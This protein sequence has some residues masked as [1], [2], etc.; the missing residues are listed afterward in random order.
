MR[1]S[2]GS[3]LVAAVLERLDEPFEEWIPEDPGVDQLGFYRLS[4]PPLD[5]TGE[6]VATE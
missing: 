6:S 1:L 3:P 4:P 2:P 5:V